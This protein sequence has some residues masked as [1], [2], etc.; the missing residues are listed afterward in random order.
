MRTITIAHVFRQRAIPTRRCLSM[1]MEVE[2]GTHE[3]WSRPR[4]LL[5]DRLPQN[6]L[7][8]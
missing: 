3:I 2:C 6:S 4:A 1:V 8:W 5:G 7:A